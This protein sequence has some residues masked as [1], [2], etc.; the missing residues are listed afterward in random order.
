MMIN[1]FKDTI[2]I[3]NV[4]NTAQVPPYTTEYHRTV[5][6]QA[7]WQSGIIT[8]RRDNDR[9]NLNAVNVYIKDTEHYR[10][11]TWNDDGLYGISERA[12]LY[13]AAPGDIIVYGKVD[14]NIST[15]SE[16]NELMTKYKPSGV[17]CVIQAKANIF[18]SKIDHIYAT[19]KDIRY[20]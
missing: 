20:E 15:S 5:I 7:S 6:N 4:I 10:P 17:F 12:G 3:F 8:K 11:P 2:T 1:I 18:G 13:T 9:S 16:F 14:D 19:N